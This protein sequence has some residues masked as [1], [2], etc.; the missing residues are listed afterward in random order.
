MLVIQHNY[1]N[2]YKSTILLL[3]ITLN[4]RVE[5]VCLQKPIIGKRSI[6]HDIFNFY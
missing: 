5:I 4:L 3:E 6:N 2:E 1:S